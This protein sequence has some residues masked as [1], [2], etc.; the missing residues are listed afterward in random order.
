M[1]CTIAHRIDLCWLHEMAIAR[2]VPNVIPA[3]PLPALETW[4]FPSW[5]RQ[6]CRTHF[7]S[8]GKVGFFPYI[9]MPTR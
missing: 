5:R 7:T 2:A 9:R 8:S 1:P 6:A 3:L 4:L